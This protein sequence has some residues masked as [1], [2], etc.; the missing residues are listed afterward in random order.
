MP[1][2][3]FL[4][5]PMSMGGALNSTPCNPIIVRVNCSIAATVGDG[6]VEIMFNYVN[7]SLILCRQ[8]GVYDVHSGKLTCLCPSPYVLAPDGISCIGIIM[9]PYFSHLAPSVCRNVW[10]HAP[11]RVLFILRYLPPQVYI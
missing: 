3:D 9:S 1:P 7:N 10:G 5:V 4:P 11:I 6:A 8:F 2:E